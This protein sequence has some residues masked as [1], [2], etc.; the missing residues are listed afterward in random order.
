MG[1]G[2]GHWGRQ[3]MTQGLAV[4]ESVS[5]WAPGHRP[6]RLSLGIGM[7]MGNGHGHGP[8]RLGMVMGMGMGA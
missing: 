4:R 8:G 5:A 7:G 3:C 1:G 6:G 2:A